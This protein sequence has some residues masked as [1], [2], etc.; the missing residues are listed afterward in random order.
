MAQSTPSRPSRPLRAAE[1]HERAAFPR[2]QAQGQRLPF[3][4][5]FYHFLLKLS[6]RAFFLMVAV[7]FLGVNVLFA[8]LYMAVPGSVKEASTF[9]DH[10]FFSVETLATIGYGEMH[11][12]NT[13]SHAIV[14]VEA[15]F[16]IL[17]TAL[18]TGLAFVRFARP[19]AKIL[20]SDHMV[21]CPRNGVPHLMFRMANWR[22]NQIGEAQLNVLLLVTETTEEGD[23]MRKPVRLPLVR[24]KNPVF[25]LTW[26]A[27]HK[28]D[29]T[30]PLY[31]DGF[32]KLLRE[33]SEIFVSVM[34]LDETLM[35]TITARWRY[36]LNDI[37]RDHR[38]ADILETLEDGTRVINYDKFHDLIP[39][40]PT[41]LSPR[42]PDA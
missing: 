3:H 1:K 38:F 22:R 30:S 12:T 20:F 37:V 31:K 7:A 40:S 11:P 21:I 33:R 8:A 28:I 36:T 10:F 2:I 9:L 26:T 23:S 29:E 15:L 6:W 18:I 34:G 25:A 27:M 4:E 17:S 5:D 39:V 16:G 32:D 13:W 41:S 19:T 35:Q 42:A 14:S 24:D